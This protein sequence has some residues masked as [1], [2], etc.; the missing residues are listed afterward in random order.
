MAA[1]VRKLPGLDILKPAQQGR[2]DRFC[3][4]Y[5]IINAIDLALYPR[6]QLMPS[7]RQKLFDAGGLPTK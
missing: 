5:A 1:A 4:L 7:Q 2:L 6:G 3:G